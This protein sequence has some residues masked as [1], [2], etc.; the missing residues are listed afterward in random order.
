MATIFSTPTTIT[1]DSATSSSAT[2]LGQAAQALSVGGSVAFGTGPVW[3]Y[4]DAVTW[5]TA[6]IYYD[7]TR[8]LV[9]AVGKEHGGTYEHYVYN[10]S[11]NS[12]GGNTA[13][14]DFL[15]GHYWNTCFDPA[16]G[17]YY[18]A[19][20][21]YNPIYKYVPGSGWSTIAN[22][23]ASVSAGF[24][25]IGWHPNLYGTGDG[26]IVL[27]EQTY[28]HAWRRSKNTWQTIQSGQ[29]NASYNGGS[30]AWDSVNNRVWV[31]TGMSNR[32]AIVNAGSGGTIG[33]VST[34]TSSPIGVYGGGES[35]G[36]GKVIAHPYTAGKFLLLAADSYSV[37]SSTNSGASWSSAGYSHPFS[38]N[39]GQWTCGPIPAYGVVWGLA[40]PGPGSMS[41]LWKPP[42]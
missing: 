7:P 34:S 22:A 24:A 6:T 23:P 4:R 8:K 42:A 26:G 20:N 27:V 32:A 38:A 25:G 3:K 30:G 10:E 29:S 2:A 18:F 5:Q 31:G 35:S 1:I 39:G 9:H 12:W 19:L 33:S 40:S 41:R 36:G 16:E 14:S 37:W 21:G 17:A 15:V 13:P 28:T 11:S